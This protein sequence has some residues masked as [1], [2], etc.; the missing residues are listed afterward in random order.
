MIQTQPP[1][2]P[3]PPPPIHR[4]QAITQSPCLALRCLPFRDR[5]ESGDCSGAGRWDLGWGG[6]VLGGVP[7]FPVV[8]MVVVG[9]LRASGLCC[10]VLFCAVLACA[11]L[12]FPV[13][14]TCRVLC[15]AVL[16]SCAVL[17][18]PHV[19]SS[20]PVRSCPVLSCDVISSGPV[21][22]YPVLSPCPVPCRTEQP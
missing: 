1:P 8:M 21:L 18:C 5:G 6:G 19:V 13:L 22:S 2:P 11:V 15:C 12:S 16:S 14:L 3:P 7:G 9:R 10:A 20:G 17:S 4:W